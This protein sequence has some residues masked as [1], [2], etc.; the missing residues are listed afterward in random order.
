MEDFE[1]LIDKGLGQL[2]QPPGQVQKLRDVLQEVQ[3]VEKRLSELKVK[4][5]HVQEEL[6]ATLA[7]NLRK[8]LPGLNVGLNNGNCIINYKSR[9]LVCRP[10][11]QSM[12]WQFEPNEWGRRFVRQHGPMTGL[13]DDLAPLSDAIA[14]FYT[15]RYKSLGGYNG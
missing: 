12:R 1:T 6:M 15:N 13:S 14:S 9:A 10:D 4:M 5:R 2:D 3:L 11:H 7:T 8:R